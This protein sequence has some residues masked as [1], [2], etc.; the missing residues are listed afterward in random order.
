MTLYRAPWRVGLWVR[1]VAMFNEEAV[2]STGASAAL[3]H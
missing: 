1:L 2:A 3:C